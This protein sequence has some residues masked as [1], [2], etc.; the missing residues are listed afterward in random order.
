MLCESVAAAIVVAVIITKRG[1]VGV[2]GWFSRLS[3]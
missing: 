1:S 3:I 2:L